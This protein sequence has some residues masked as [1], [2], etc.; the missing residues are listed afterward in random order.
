MKNRSDARV[1]TD[2]LPPSSK[3]ALPLFE[4]ESGFTVPLIQGDSREAKR[5][6]RGSLTSHL[7]AALVALVLSPLSSWADT[8]PRQPGIKILQYTFDVTLGDASDELVVKDTIALEFL[9]AGVRGLDLDL[10]NLIKQPPPA[11]RLNPC[12]VPAPRP[13]R[14]AAPNASAPEAPSSV[15]R[16]MA[17]TGITGAN[18]A[19]LTF[20]HENDRLH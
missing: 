14:G 17:V 8:Y 15:G 20:V 1:A 6:G 9:A 10:C 11:D 4:G 7:T 13:P 12:L 18:G 19:A 5:S 3:A 2:P 16:G